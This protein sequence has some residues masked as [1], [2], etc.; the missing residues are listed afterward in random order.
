VLWIIECK[1]SLGLEVL[2][3]LIYWQRRGFAHYFSAA[4]F[5]KRAPGGRSFGNTIHSETVGF[6]MDHFDFG[7]LGVHPEHLSVERNRE[8]GLH[9][10]PP[11]WLGTMGSYLHPDQQ[12]RLGA[13]STGGNMSTPFQRTCDRLRELV[14]EHGQIAPKE[15]I[16]Q[17]DHHYQTESSARSSLIVWAAKGKIRGVRLKREGRAVYF[18]KALK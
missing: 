7:W 13:G 17:M 8:A 12:T 5:L 9:R 18:A 10:L 14:L 3:Q 1:K 11:S 6:M 15:A 4:T 2:D 16:A